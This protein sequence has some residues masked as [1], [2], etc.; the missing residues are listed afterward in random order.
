LLTEKAD[1]PR[2]PFFVGK[3]KL[4]VPQSVPAFLGSRLLMGTVFAKY[5]QNAAIRL[6]P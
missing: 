2:S 3:P 1:R 5:G 4:L 6:L